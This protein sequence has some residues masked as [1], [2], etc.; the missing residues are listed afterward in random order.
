MIAIGVDD[1]RCV[2][3]HE[4]AGTCVQSLS[5]QDSAE[6]ACLGC[7]STNKSTKPAKKQSLFAILGIAI[8]ES[9][10][11]TSEVFC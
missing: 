11:R 2:E 5:M 1:W 9:L 4:N 3:V 8:W 10:L 7:M 6:Y